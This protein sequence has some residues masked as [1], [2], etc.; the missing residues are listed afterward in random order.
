MR[1]VYAS[2]ISIQVTAWNVNQ[3]SGTIT[4]DVT[5]SG[6]CGA[7]RCWWML[8]GFYMDAAVDQFQGGIATGDAY[9]DSTRP[10]AFTKRLTGTRTGS[11][12]PEI[13][14]LKA[15]MELST[16]AWANSGSHVV[17]A[18]YADPWVTLTV[19]KWRVDPVTSYVD[20]DVTMN[21]GGLG[22]RLGPCSDVRCAWGID[23][24]YDDGTTQR[25]VYALYSYSNSGDRMWSTTRRITRTG[26]SGP[27]VTHL[28]AY[29]RPY[30]CA[31]PCIYESIDTGLDF[32]GSLT[33]RN[34]D[35]VP[36]SV[37][38]ATA[39]AANRSRFC[40]PLLLKPYPNTNGNSV[41]DF[42]ESCEALVLSGASLAEVLAELGAEAP[43][44]VD[45]LLDYWA[46]HPAPSDEQKSIPLPMLP[47]SGEQ[48][49]SCDP[50]IRNVE[51]AAGHIET[52][53]S[54][55]SGS[56]ASLF[57][58]WVEWRWLVGFAQAV[59]W[60]IPS[61]TRC[62]RVLQYPDTHVG[63]IRFRRMLASE[64]QG[65]PTHWFTVVTERNGVL[66][67]AY[68]GTPDD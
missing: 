53:H 54:W 66:V 47:S 10:V 7:S 29:V 24:V 64:R 41:N 25:V 38:L 16:G 59:Q 1:P 49:P 9:G 31:S 4:Y 12:A 13:T 57:Y 18:P 34:V 40:E 17:S 22:Q 30:S 68:P 60:P 19:D 6:T 21:A 44:T 23:A 61:G 14:H 48:D 45:E 55:K 39:Y 50:Q 58:P 11:A 28:R 27:R 46:R 65:E 56:G 62:V 26:W 20:Y 5:V 36:Y 32:V 42:F 33:V 51:G 37:A 15:K 2:G 35:I 3:S 63:V 8:D 52:R 67:S 43:E